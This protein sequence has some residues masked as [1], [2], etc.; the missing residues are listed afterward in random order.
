MGI[1][2]IETPAPVEFGDI[3]LVRDG[4][5]ASGHGARSDAAGVNALRWETIGNAVSNWLTVDLRPL[6]DGVENAHLDLCFGM[7]DEDVALASDAVLA[8]PSTM[9]TP[10]GAGHATFAEHLAALD[11]DVVTISPTLQ[12]AGGTNVLAVGERCVIAYE[13]SVRA[14]LGDIAQHVGVVVLPCDGEELLKTG[15][16]P[17][18]LTMPL[19]RT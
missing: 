17:R 9:L 1:A 16:G 4:V 15:G 3:V 7:I 11:V 5:V 18:C 8:C 10:S 14:G 12:R 6:G 19:A 2:C 13:Q